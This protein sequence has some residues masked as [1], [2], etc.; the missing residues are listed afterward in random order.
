MATRLFPALRPVHPLPDA[1]VTDEEYAK[2]VNKRR[3]EYG[4]FIVGE[5]GDECVQPPTPSRDAP[6]RVQ[7]SIRAPPSRPAVCQPDP[8]ARFFKPPPSP[9]YVDIGEED[10]WSKP[11]PGASDDEMDEDGSAKKRKKGAKGEAVDAKKGKPV[12]DKRD[13]QRLANMFAKNAAAAAAGGVKRK[14]PDGIAAQEGAQDADS[15]LEDILAGVGGEAMAPAAPAAFRPAPVARAAPPSNQ[16]RRPAP[17]QP[18]SVAATPATTMKSTLATPSAPRQ[19]AAPAVRATPRVTFADEAAA[20]KGEADD[21]YF[22]PPPLSPPSSQRDNDARDDAP[23][24]RDDDDDDARAMDADDE[25]PSPAAAAANARSKSILKSE[26]KPAAA[27]AAGVT[28]A[29][30]AVGTKNPA[31][32]SAGDAYAA[33][34]SSAANADADVS[35]AEDAAPATIADD[36]LP[37]DEDDTLPFF[38][39]DAHEDISAPGT[40]FLF[41]R[42]PVDAKITAGE[43]VSACAV[44]QN[45]Q[46]C[47]FVVPK[48]EVFEDPEDEISNLEDAAARAARA[49]AESPEDEALAT[50]AKKAKGALLRC[51]QGRAADLKAEIREMLLARGIEQFTLKPVKRSYCFEREDIPRGSQYVLKVRYPAANAAL[52]ADVRGNNFVCVLGTQTPMLEHLLVKSR[53]MGPSWIAVGGA[54]RVP[55]AQKRSWSTLEVATSNGHK[56][57]RPPRNDGPNREP[58]T[59]T[60]AALNLKTV[61]NHRQNVNEIASASLVYV[62]GVRVDQP[63]PTTTLNSIEHVRHFSVVRRLDGVSMP[64]GW[65]QMVQKE[66]AEHPVARR[67]KSSVLSSQTSER[68]L[69]S[70]LLA[71][72]GQ[73]DADVIVGHNIAGFD[74]D[75]LLHRLQ[76]NKVPHWSK[77]GR[78]KR[79]RF[80]NLGGGGQNYGGGAG[81]GALSCVAGRLLADTYLSAR[82]FVKEVSYTLTALAQNQ[83]KMTRHEVPSTDIPGKFGTAA[84]LL[85]LTKATEHDAWLSMGLLFHLSVLPLTRQLSNIAGNLWTKTLQHTRAGRVEYLLLHEFHARKYLLPDKL[86]AKERKFGRGGGGDDVDFGEGGDE[87]GVKAGKKKGGPAYAGGLVLEPKKGLYDKYVLMLDF[88][89]LYPSII[90]E[91]DICFTTVARPKADPSDPSAPPPPT[92]LPEPPAG[93]PGG[94]NAAV[95]PQ[96]I[97]KLV[98]RRREVKNMIKSERNPAVRQQLDIRQ[99]ALKLTANSM[100]GCLGFAASRF[101]AKPL[102]ELTTLQGREILQST[103]DLAQGNLGMDVIY[104]DTDSIMINTNSNNLQEVMSVGNA[105]KKEV[106]KRYKLLEIEIDGVYKSMLLLKKKKYAALKVEGSP[107]GSGG[108]VT[109]MEQKGLDIVRRDWSPLAKQQGNHVLNTILSGRPAEDVVEDIHESLRK[110]REDLVAGAV[111]MDQFIITKQLTKRPEDYPDAANQ[112]HV[113]VALR[114]RAAGKYEGTQQG[115]TVPYVIAVKSDASA[116][117]IASGKAGASGGKGLADRAYHP[118]EVNAPGSGLKLDLHYY[119]TQQV[120]PVVS[121]L[122]QPIEGTDAAHI[123]NCLGL[124]PSKFHAQVVHNSGGGDDDELLAPA[125]ALDDEERFKRCAPLKLR[126]AAG[127]F[128]FAG[129]DAIL[130]GKVDGHAA[131]APPAETQGQGPS[132]DAKENSAPSASAATT[133]APNGKMASSTVKPLSGH[134]LANQVR[135]ATRAAISAYYSGPLRSDDELAPAE[136]RNVS[137]RTAGE[138]AGANVEPGTLPGDPK[139][140]GIMSKVTTEANLYTQLVHFRRLLSMPEALARMPEKERDAARARM[141]P[142]TAEALRLATAALDETL[143]RSSYRWINLS[144]LY[145]AAGVAC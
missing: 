29:G 64:P 106:N 121:R 136:T 116:E 101:Y 44:V 139:L 18:P 117:D 128:E 112:A 40:V 100:Y 145:G 118:D 63:T 86:S 67:T 13:R 39:L 143:E 129:V 76:A 56:S 68:G 142:A 140:Q 8:I 62:R 49:A 99:L 75:V 81:I 71:R 7:I 114:L 82:D 58:P 50:A 135:L 97:R 105:V 107:D 16:F 53:V 19:G 45:M 32:P 133:P 3:E 11:A 91:Y 30:A 55:D 125:S 122:C 94:P 134:A 109:S 54:V 43:T 48:P 88:N 83:L 132:G 74:L 95:L 85:S 2:I 34:F 123:A 104:G 98:Q 70:V 35:V 51:L 138:G 17:Q 5:D 26:E 113:Q 115:E 131:L 119:L 130:R 14:T 10:D 77:I 65:D 110:C 108:V 103:V 60:V 24:A 33:V 6:R 9:R 69:L 15:L 21:E 23:I 42:V 89:S 61:V 124:D 144:E 102:A 137:L 28:A 92:Q 57:I 1:Q 4:G 90:Q 87:G 46:R 31:A 52:P 80:P 93:G 72:L 126:A 36:S 66:N 127:A 38:L 37:L 22:I 141:P 79:T 47:M 84:N 20:A 120:H 41:G 111:T 73:L 96:V 59:L 25:P 78:L 27:P 12:A